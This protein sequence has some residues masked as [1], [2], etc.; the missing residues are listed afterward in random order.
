VEVPPRAGRAAIK[1]ARGATLILVLGTSGGR[2]GLGGGI[3]LLGISVADW[4]LGL[5]SE[6][7]LAKVGNVGIIAA[8]S[9]RDG[10]E[11]EFFTCVKRFAVRCSSRSR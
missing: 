5:G 4:E 11:R 3:D 8:R 6:F 2:N 7:P 10:V 9:L 1:R